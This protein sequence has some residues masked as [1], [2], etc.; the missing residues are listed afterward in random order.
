S[1]GAEVAELGDH[2]SIRRLDDDDLVGLVRGYPDT[3]L[4]V[5]DETVGPVDAVHE[6]ERLARDERR[7]THRD[8][9][10]RV[11]ARIGDEECCLAL[12]EGD[13]VG[14][15]RGHAGRREERVAYP[16]RGYTAAL[17]RAADAASERIRYVDVAGPVERES[18]EPGLRSRRRG[19]GG[20][21]HEDLG[22]S[23]EPI[24]A[25]HVRPTE[26]DHEQLASRRME[27]Q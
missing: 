22:D 11:V 8:L 3:V 14:A 26:I 24:D 19:Q 13:P 17:A 1:D 23:S 10:D 2:A 4:N 5:D 25:Q 12:V 6:D 21:G 16:L 20:E 27:V 18:V 7:A 15:E 9:H